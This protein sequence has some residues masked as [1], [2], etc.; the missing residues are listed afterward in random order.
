MLIF[1]HLTGGPREVAR[2]SFDDCMMF[3]LL[4]GFPINA[5]EQ[6]KYYITNVLKKPQHVN[7]HQ[8]V[9]PVEQLNTYI[10]L[11]LCFYNSPSFNATI[12]PENIL[13]TE[14]ELGSHIL[15]MCPIQWQDQYNLHEKGMMPM[16][17]HSLLMS[18]E[19][20]ERVCTQEKAKSE[21]SKKA[22]HKSKNNK[23]QPGTGSTAR[24]PK[25]V[26]FEKHC[27]IC[28]MHGGMHIMHNTKDCCRYERDRKEKAN[29]HAAK[30]GRKKPNRAWQNFAQLREKLDK[31][32]KT[33]KKV[34]KKFKKCQYKD[35]N[36][37]SK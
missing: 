30:K 19:V 9:H 29:F 31:L 34:T 28:K 15:R 24:V 16:D 10:V 6:E 36:S 2:Q 35:S 37:N 32:E 11:L 20:I 22:S 13:F 17:L 8:F 7:M 4:T 18:L 14:A 5:A 23:K 33:L 25:Q 1:R 27:N 21:F 12:K 3:H 26:H